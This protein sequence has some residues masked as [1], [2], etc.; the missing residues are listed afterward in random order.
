MISYK[1]KH[2]SKIITLQKYV[3]KYLSIRFIKSFDRDSLPQP[4]ISTEKIINNYND[5]S[6]KI[7]ESKSKFDIIK[8]KSYHKT[9]EREIEK[10]EI[11]R[12]SCRERV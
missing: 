6:D 7:E 3:K 10:T 9:F 1:Q 11:G 12:A 4:K 5:K 8:S 2:I